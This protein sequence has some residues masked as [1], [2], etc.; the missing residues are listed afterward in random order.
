[1]EINIDISKVVTETLESYPSCTHLQKRF[2]GLLQEHYD[3]LKSK[4]EDSSRIGGLSAIIEEYEILL[5][6]HRSEFLQK[7]WLKINV[8]SG[9]TIDEFKAEKEV[10]LQFLQAVVHWFE[11]NKDN[12]G[13]KT[14]T[15]KEIVD[16][17]IETGMKL[18][19]DFD[20]KSAEDQAETLLNRMSIPEQK[21]IKRLQQVNVIGSDAYFREFEERK[22]WLKKNISEGEFW[23]CDIEWTKNEIHK[24]EKEQSLLSL[25]DKW[26]LQ[27]FQSRIY[28]FTQLLEKL[29]SGTKY[30]CPNTLHI[31]QSLAG[32]FDI[33][34]T[35][36]R[37]FEDF[38]FQH[39]YTDLSDGNKYRDGKTGDLDFERLI[40]KVFEFSNLLDGELRDYFFR[41]F[42]QDTEYKNRHMV[43]EADSY[44]LIK[45]I[46]ERR[47]SELP[48]SKP[49]M[50]LSKI[51]SINPMPSKSLAL[52]TFYRESQREYASLEGL[53]RKQIAEQIA[54]ENG[55]SANSFRQDLSAMQNKDKRLVR[56][57]IPRIKQVI[58]FLD[59]YPKALKYAQDE[60]KILQAR[61]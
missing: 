49:E 8:F 38:F 7:N 24:V 60:L 58:D 16:R 50:N 19:A 33:S 9:G 32:R 6:N 20:S 35:Q 37:L 48:L 54:S 28:V 29:P 57:N 59:E 51:T 52:Y 43:G 3:K 30:C 40:N 27:L 10:V 14:L 4:I 45:K 15:K 39:P 46:E 44:I 42:Y 23:T 53:N 1:M 18:N 61:H 55:L 26:R 11:K 22:A 12:Q 2:E 25:F 36:I 31:L 34:S 47:S 41:C 21:E 56:E 17:F 5:K 13:K